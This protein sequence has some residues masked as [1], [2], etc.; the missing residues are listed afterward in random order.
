MA[1]VEA[2]DS[3]KGEVAAAVGHIQAA[4]ACLEKAVELDKPAAEREKKE[5]E[6]AE[7]A[8]QPAKASTAGG[9]E[10]R[11]LSEQVIDIHLQATLLSTRLGPPNSDPPGE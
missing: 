6:E 1:R 3:V 10:L 5:A 11:L 9:R 2:A 8:G 7:K 4:R